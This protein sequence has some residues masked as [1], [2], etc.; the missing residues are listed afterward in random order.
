RAILVEQPRPYRPG[1]GPGVHEIDESHQSAA[2]DFC[3]RV[4]QQNILPRA[5]ANTLVIGRSKAHVA[6]VT[7]KVYVREAPGDCFGAAITRRIIDDDH[8]CL[9]GAKAR[10]LLNQGVQASQ[11]KRARIDRKSTRLNSSHVKISYAV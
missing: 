5:G 8:L 4:E 10:Q 2:P 3:V 1:L 6:L 11:H 9:A 7:D